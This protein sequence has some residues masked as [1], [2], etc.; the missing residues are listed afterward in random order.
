MLT[1]LSCA[2]QFKDASEKA[3]GDLSIDNLNALVV[4][5]DSLGGVPVLS[6]L[7]RSIPVITVEN[8]TSVMQVTTEAFPNQSIIS[9]PS[10]EAAV[11]KLQSLKA[12]VQFS[13]A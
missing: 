2:R 7:L 5:A 3:L 11:E 12:E 8:N 10:Y 9:V 13:P 6:C 1:G 4:P